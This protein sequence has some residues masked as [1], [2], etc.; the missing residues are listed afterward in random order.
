[1]NA[2]N[3]MKAGL[4]ATP[5]SQGENMNTLIN[6]SQHKLPQ[7]PNIPDRA[8]PITD[9]GAVEGG[10]TLNSQAI[11]AAI[12][13]A[14]AAGGGRVV[15][16]AGIWLTGAIHFKDRIELHL[17]EG[18]ELRFSQD[19]ENYL[20]VVIMQR[21]GAWCYTY[22]PFIYGH[23]CQDVALTG[24]GT[25]NG[26]GES[27]WPWK[28]NQPGMVRLRHMVADRT[29]VD[30]RV[31]GT[32][33][34]GVRPSFLQFLKSRRVLIEG[35]RFSDSPSWTLHPVQCE[36]LTIR[37]VTVQNPSKAPNTDAIDP[38]ACRRVL[39][40]H[41]HV[42]TG[43]DG[44]CLKSGWNE[45]G[46][47][48]GIPCEDVLIR[49]CTV[50]A[51]HGGFVIGSDISGGIRN[52]HVHDCVFDGTNV[53]VRIKTK[54]GRGGFV[55]EVV[56]ERLTMRKISRQAILIT[57]WYQGN[58]HDTVEI[59][60]SLPVTRISDVTVRDVTCEG[61]AEAILLRG[62][63][64]EPFRRI[65][66]ERLDITAESGIHIEATEGIRMEGGT[67]KATISVTS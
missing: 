2:E 47:E 29:P 48:A 28:K 53:G 59:D 31:F 19:P 23:E 38:D 30:K 45:D 13:A 63:P 11:A 17:E 24:Q 56:A 20:P 66:L 32:V 27:W 12:E 61:A 39:I 4:A 58:P 34:D 22:S 54:P 15:V 55:Q 21:G 49:H 60:P 7:E 1:M 52:V 18:A 57:Q 8:W 51:A 16:P 5:A 41:C 33:E 6:T 67:V 3:E 37:G 9:H 65:T 14:H 46:W 26:Q 10:K 35:V 64:H 25:L 36:D 50:L 40:E 42:D 62:M 44:I 43:D